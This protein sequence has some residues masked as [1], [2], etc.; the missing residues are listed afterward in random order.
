MAE[1]NLPE[2]SWIILDTNF[3]IDFYSKQNIYSDVFEQMRINGNTIVSI[4]L[5][6]GEFI[7]SKTRD[8]VRAKSDFFSK[9]VS[10][11]LPIDES[12]F[13]LVQPT[14]EQYGDDTT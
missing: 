11:L 1:W 10:S 6:R 4:E 9:T 3:L 8:V 2:N 5:I 14:I 7:R 12:V 13:N